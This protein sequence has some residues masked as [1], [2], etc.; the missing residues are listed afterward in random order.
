MKK[1]F[2]IFLFFS[3]SFLE[4]SNWATTRFEAFWKRNFK[5]MSFREPIY[6]FNTVVSAGFPSPAGDIFASKINLEDYS[7]GV[8][9]VNIISDTGI[10]YTKRISYIK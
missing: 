7:E 9:I 1:I 6:F 10:L 8:Y 4:E 5:Q 2:L 3:F